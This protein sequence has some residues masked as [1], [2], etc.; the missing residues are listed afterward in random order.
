M[1]LSVMVNIIVNQKWLTIVAATWII[2]FL[3]IVFNIIV[4]GIACDNQKCDNLE[5]QGHKAP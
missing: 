1:V 3:V 2:I 4:G 5:D